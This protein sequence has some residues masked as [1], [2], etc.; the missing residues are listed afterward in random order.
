MGIEQQNDF[1]SQRNM[2]KKRLYLFKVTVQENPLISRS[3]S[4]SLAVADPEGVKGVR[5]C[6]LPLVF[7]YPMKMK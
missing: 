7:K 1:F 6:P 5:L 2:W 4:L 3:G